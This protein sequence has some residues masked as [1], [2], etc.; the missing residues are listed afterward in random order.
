[1]RMSRRRPQC[2][3][4]E[5][6]SGP[7]RAREQK[8]GQGARVMLGWEARTHRALRRTE[9]PT[10]AAAAA[11][12]HPGWSIAVKRRQA[13]LAPQPPRPPPPARALFS[14]CPFTSSFKFVQWVT[15]P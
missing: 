12:A 3:N 2:A 4:G 5:G 1:M 8:G 13:A 7:A 14:F 10:A 11:A 9:S 15:G 6:G